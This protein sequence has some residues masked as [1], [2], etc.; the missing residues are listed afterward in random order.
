[1]FN[2]VLTAHTH[3]HC[4]QTVHTHYVVEWRRRLARGRI[5][6]ATTKRTRVHARVTTPPEGRSVFIDLYPPPPVVVDVVVAVGTHPTRR[7]DALYLVWPHFGRCQFKKKVLV[8]VY[9]R[10]YI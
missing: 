4:T 8:L 5:V 6:T 1:M 10:L 9:L 3:T 2:D 7:A